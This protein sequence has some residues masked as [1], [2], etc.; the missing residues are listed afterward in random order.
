MTIRHDNR[1][2]AAASATAAWSK[3]GAT[4]D[5]HAER[6]TAIV[7]SI[8]TAVWLLDLLVPTF[9]QI[10]HHDDAAYIRSGPWLVD[11]GTL[12]VLAWGPLISFVYG[13]VYVV[14]QVT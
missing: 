7:L 3:L 8:V 4:W 9:G 10:G 6:N 13:L 12:R 14:V 11:E 5:D 2:G 1:S